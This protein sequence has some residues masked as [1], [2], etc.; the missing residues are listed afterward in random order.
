LIVEIFQIV[1]SEHMA[2]WLQKETVAETSINQIVDSLPV[3]LPPKKWKMDGRE[4]CEMLEKV[5]LAC[6]VQ[7]LKRTGDSGSN[8]EQV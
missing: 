7:V 8:P 4:E 2:A 5:L 6:Q 1:R 3:P